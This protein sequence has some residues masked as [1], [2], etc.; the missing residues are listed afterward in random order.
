[1][2]LMDVAVMR[3]RR[4]LL[5]AA[6]TALALAALACG[7]GET[8]SAP[9]EGE[10]F[11][12]VPGGQVWYR[13]DGSGPGT[14]LLLLH[15]GPGGTS[16]YLRPLGRLSDERPVVFYDQLGGGYSDRPTADSLWQMERFVE[17][18]R[19]VRSALGLEEIHL[20]GHSW[21][22]MLAIEYLLTDPPGVR[23]VVLASMT[24]SVEQWLADTGERVATLPD[25]LR[26]VIRRHE[27]A[28]TTD[29]PAYQAA[30]MEF[31]HRY[32]SLSDPWPA[33]LD[34]TFATFGEEVYSTMWGPSEFTATGR[35]RSWDARGRLDEIEVPV[36]VTVGDTDEMSVAS[37]RDMVERLP[38]AR[39]EV[40]EDAAHLT[41]VDRPDAYA[42]VI[43]NFLAEVGDR[44]KPK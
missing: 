11:I 35:L 44:P 37:A 39:L 9:P 21:G 30:V 12:D 7:T 17:E 32:L 14:P 24:P 16:H 13:V 29:D 19:Q 38:D 42:R 2:N 8:G 34:S 25:S 43:R 18:L 26:T 22:A 20:L 5:V 28:G 4:G 40:I 10:G 41:M 23:S 15:G 36:L 27:E 3:T 6:I 31:Y 1:M 33:I